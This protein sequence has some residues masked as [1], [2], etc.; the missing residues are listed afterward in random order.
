M[1]KGY[2]AA[3]LL[4]CLLLTGCRQIVPTP[5]TDPVQTDIPGVTE[6][7]FNTEPSTQPTE[8][9][10]APTQPTTEPAQPTEPSTQPTEPATQP[11]EPATQPTEPATQ[12][13]EPAT[14]PTEP[15]TQPTEPS[16]EDPLVAQYEA[17][18][19]M[20][21]NAQMQYMESFSSVEAFFSWYNA[22]KD[23]Y[24]KANPSIEIGGDGSVDLDQ[25]LGGK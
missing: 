15:A 21:P 12:P 4:F 10:A 2:I 7:I 3:I 18:Q 25:I 22:A 6:N 20:S 23:A 1:K 8:T 14:Q 13:T 11:T 19:D 16:E 17:F 9:T 5:S 24:E